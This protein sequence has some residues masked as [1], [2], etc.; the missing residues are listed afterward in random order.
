[1]ST[2]I[3][4][5]YFL[6]ALIIFSFP[7]VPPIAFF[8]FHIYIFFSLIYFIPCLFV[9][10]NMRRR[11]GKFTAEMGYLERVLTEMFS[12]ACV[13]DR[14]LAH[15]EIVQLKETEYEAITS[16]NFYGRMP[17]SGVHFEE[18]CLENG[19][20]ST[21]RTFACNCCRLKIDSTEESTSMIISQI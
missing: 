10:C 1:M 5:H 14:E 6:S 7:S 8:M 9:A 11:S 13:C 17:I 16:E 15:L 3:K 21:S 4:Q 2:I 20:T 18:L 12:T 19:T